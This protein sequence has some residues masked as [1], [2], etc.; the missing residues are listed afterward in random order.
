[1]TV[2]MGQCAPMLRVEAA[3][4]EETETMLSAVD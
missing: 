1:M 4:R 3:P 2:G